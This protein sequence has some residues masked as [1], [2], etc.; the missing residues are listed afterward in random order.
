MKPTPKGGVRM[1]ELGGLLFEPGSFAVAA[2]ENSPP[3]LLTAASAGTGNH[4]HR[5]QENR[6]PNAEKSVQ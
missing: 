2:A 5:C 6:M 1:S 4:I 3:A